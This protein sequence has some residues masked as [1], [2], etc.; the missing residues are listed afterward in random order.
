MRTTILH[1]GATMFQE[2]LI[3]SNHHSRIP[4][5]LSIALQTAL[6]AALLAIPLLHPDILPLLPTRLTA[7]TPPTLH[8]PP[9]PPSHP[10]VV[11]TTSIPAPATSAAQPTQIMPRQLPGILTDAQPVDTPALAVG[12]SGIPNPNPLATLTA[13]GPAN[14]HIVVVGPAAGTLNAPL[15]VSTGVL[16]GMLLTPIQPTYPPI[17]RLT[18]T[19]GS[20]VIQA[21]IS[22]SGRIESAHVVSGPAV[23]Q[24]AALTAVRE[25]R[26]RP[27]LLNSQPT[28]VETT[29]TINFRLGP[30]P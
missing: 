7:L 12:I 28:E 8:V 17:A 6:I 15:H 18:R 2:S 16:A 20:V 13:A 21:I 25:A 1:R 14:P 11:T 3:A 4:A 23:L 9:P 24:S 30:N 10:V 29:I 19:E 5:L 22:K 27:F 26:Y